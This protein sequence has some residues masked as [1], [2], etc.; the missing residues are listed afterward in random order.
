MQQSIWIILIIQ[1]CCK[2]G[3]IC[4][5]YPLDPQSC[6]EKT[7]DIK[8]QYNYV[9]NKCIE[10]YNTDYGCMN[11]LNRNSC[12][13][14]LVDSFNNELRCLFHEKCIQAT[15][16]HLKTLECNTNFSKFSCLNVNQMDCVW[17]AQCLDYKSQKPQ[18]HYQS[19]EEYYSQS[20][21]P[22]M[23]AKIQK[24][25]CFHGGITM[26]YKCITIIDS[27]LSEMKCSQKGINKNGCILI[28]TKNETCIFKNNQC[29]YI[30]IGSLDSCEFLNKQACLLPKMNNLQCQW[31]QQRCTI[32]KNNNYSCN[33]L[34]DVNPSVCQ[35]FEGICSYNIQTQGCEEVS[36]SQL[37]KLPCS[38][39]GLSQA[40]C[41]LIKNNY[42]TF[43]KGFCETLSEEDLYIYK[44]DMFLNEDSCTNIKTQFQY[45]KWDGMKCERTFMN[46][47]QDCKEKIDNSIKYNGLF[48]QHISKEVACKYDLSSKQCVPSLIEDECNSPYLNFFGCLSITAHKQT[49]QWTTKGC[50]LITVF[51]F[52]TTCESLGYANYNSCAQV[53]ENLSS[54]CYYEKSLYKCKKVDLSINQKLFLVSIDCENK[55]L[56]LNRIL[57]ASVIKPQTACRWHQNEC[58]KINNPKEI[59]DVSCQEMLFSNSI[60]C[61]MTQFN[62]E[63]CRFEESAKGCINSVKSKFSC[64]SPGLNSFACSQ[65]DN[66]CYFNTNKFQCQVFKT[67][68]SSQTTPQDQD[69]N[70]NSNNNQKIYEGQNSLN[71]I[72]SSPTKIICL[73]ITKPGQLCQWKDKL[74]KCGEVIVTLNQKCTSFKNVNSNVCASVFMENPDFIPYNEKQSVGY[75]K[76][77]TGTSSCQVL[78][79]SEICDT[80]CCTEN[81]FI[82]INRHTCS[83]LTNKADVYCYFDNYRCKELTQNL[84]DVTNKEAVKQYFNANEFNCSQM[85]KKSCHL[86]EWSTQQW[87]YFNGI[88]CQNVNFENQSNFKIFTE[89]P[90]IL[91]KYACLAIEASTT[92]YNIDKYFEYDPINHRCISQQYQISPPFY[93][94][95]E[96]V[97]GNSNICLRFTSNNYCKWDK[98]QLKCVTIPLDEFLDMTTCYQNQNIKA[99]SE[100]P[101]EACFFSFDLDKCISAVTYVPCSYFDSQGLVSQK[102]CA[103]IDLPQ[104][105]CEWSNYSCQISVKTSSNCDVKGANK[106]TCYKNT[107]GKCRWSNE[108]STCYEIAT[109]L[110]IDELGCDD[111]LN[112]VLCKLVKKESC[113]WDETMYECVRF[114]YTHHND[115]IFLDQ[116]NFYNGLACLNITGA[117]YKYDEKNNKCILIQDSINRNSCKQMIND[118]ACLYLTRGQ[119]CV[120]DTNQMP[121]CQVFTDDQSLCTT[122]KSIS[123]EVCMKIPKQC[124]FSKSKLQCLI[125]EIPKS[126]TCSS[127]NVQLK[128]GNHYNKLSCS[129]IDQSLTQTYQDDQCYQSEEKKQKCNYE[130]YCEWHD[131]IYGC[132]VKKLNNLIFDKEHTEKSSVFEYRY[133]IDN[134]TNQCNSYVKTQEIFSNT[135]NV[136]L[137]GSSSPLIC[138]QNKTCDYQDKICLSNLD[139]PIIYTIPISINDDGSI[140][141]GTKQSQLCTKKC[142][143]KG[144]IVCDK[145]NQQKPEEILKNAEMNIQKCQGKCNNT[146]KTSCFEDFECGYKTLQ[147]QDSNNVT[148]EILIQNICEKYQC[149]QGR[150]NCNNNNKNDCPDYVQKRWE[151]KTAQCV[152][153]PNYIITPKCK[154]FGY[155]ELKCKNTFSKVLCLYG[156]LE[157]CMFDLNQGGC[158]QLEGNENKI[159]DCSAISSRC[160]PSNLALACDP[161]KPVCKNSTHCLKEFLNSC[162]ASSN[163]R[164]LCKAGQTKIIPNQETCFSLQREIQQ[165]EP[166]KSIP[167][168]LSCQMM[169]G[170]VS[171][172]LCALANDNCRYENNYC[173]ST[174]PKMIENEYICDKS[175]SKSLCEK[176]NCFFEFIGYC[177]QKPLPPQLNT[178]MSNKYYLCHEVNQLNIENKLNVCVQVEQACKFIN[179]KCEDATHYNC[180]QLKGYYT[181][182][183]ACI[184][185]Q[186]AS[187]QYDISNNICTYLGL[188]N[189]SNCY[190]LNQ[191]ACLQ[192]TQKIMC[193]WEDYECKEIKTITGS[194]KR[195]CSIYNRDACIQFQY[196]CWFD[197]NIK[198]CIKFDPKLGSCDLLLNKDLCMYSLKESCLWDQNN[199]ICIKNDQE[200]T[201]CQGLNKFGCLNQSILQCVWSDIYGCQL[202]DFNNNSQS[203][204]S[205][206]G[207]SQKSYIT[208]FSKKVCSSININLNCFQDNYYRCRKIII[209]DMIKCD[210]NGLNK[211]GC[212]NRSYGKCQYLDEQKECI[213]IQNDQIGCIDSLNKEACISQKQTCKFENNTC[214]FHQVNKITDII[215]QIENFPYSNSVCSYLDKQIQQSFLYSQVQNRCIDVSNR[216][217]FIDN[218]SMVGIN[219][220]ACQQKTILACEY[221]SDENIC[222]KTEQSILKTINTCF[223][224]KY[225]NWV[226]CISLSSQCKFIQNKCLPIESKDNCQYLQDQ[227]IIVKSSICA[228]RNDKGCKLNITSN[229]CEI[230]NKGDN[231]QCT[232][233][234]LN[235]IGCLFQTKGYLCK[236]QQDQCFFDFQETVCEDLINEDK[237]YSIKTKGQYCRFDQNK[238]C[239]QI[240]NS[241]NELLKCQHSFKTNPI[242]CSISIDVPCFYN[243]SSKTCIKYQNPQGE[244]QLTNQDYFIFNLQSFNSQ[245]CQ[246]NSIARFD[247][248]T[249]SGKLKTQ[250]I[251]EC[252]E[253][254]EVNLNTLKCNDK[255]NEQSCISIQTPFQ[256]CQFTNQ[257]CKLSNLENFKKLQCQNISKIN[258]GMFCQVNQDYACQFNKNTNSCETVISSN[259]IYCVD[260]NPEV[261]GFSKKA[262]NLNRECTFSNG[263]YQL[264]ATENIKYCNEF[265][266]DQCY[267]PK[268]EGCKIYQKKCMAINLTEYSTINCN[269]A[270]NKLG[271]LNI[272]TEKQFCQYIEEKCELISLKEK[273]NYCLEF[274]SI[275]SPVFC[276][277]TIDIPCKYNSQ[278]YKC[279]NAEAEIEF[280]CIR[281]LNQRACLNLTKQSL[282]CQFYNY[283]EIQLTNQDYF[284]FNLQSFN[285]QACQINSIARFDSITISGKL[286]TQWIGE[287]VEIFEV[288]LNTLKCNDK[289]NEQSCISIQT[290]FQYCQFTNQQC[291]L[292]NLENFK[293]LQCQN[294]SKINSGMFC[295]VNQDY[296]CQF[297]KNTNSCETVISSNQIYCVDDNP[298]VLGFSKKACNLN[299]ECT[300]SNGCYQLKATENIKYCNEFSI[301]QCYKPKR[302]GCKIYQKKCMAINLTEYSTINCNEAANKLGC[303]NIKTEKQFCQYIEEKCE[304]I[305]LKEKE[306]YC[307]EFSSIN[308]PRIKLKGLFESYKIIFIICLFQDQFKCQ[309]QNQQCSK[310]SEQNLK[311]Q[312]CEMLTNVSRQ[313]CYEKEDSVCVFNID[314]LGCIEITPETCDQVQ[315]KEQCNKLQD[316]PCYW[317]FVELQCLFKDKNL[318]DGCQEIQNQW[319]SQRACLDVEK[320]GQMCK[321]DQ[322]CGAYVQTQ[323]IG[324]SKQL[325]KQSCLKQVFHQ[326]FWNIYKVDIKKT[327]QSKSKDK[328]EFGICHEYNQESD[329]QCNSN[330]S[331]LTC[332]NINTPNIFCKWEDNECKEVKNNQIFTL[333]SFSQ[334]NCNTCGIINDGSHA[335]CDTKNFKCQNARLQKN[336]LCDLPG[337]N[338]EACFY[339]QGQPCKWDDTIKRCLKQNEPLNQKKFN[340]QDSCKL[341]DVN[342]QV[343]SQL[344]IPLPCGFFE[345]SCDQVDLNQISCDYPGLNQYACLKIKNHPCGWIYDDIQKNYEC[346]FIQDFDAC[347][348]YNYFVNPFVCTQVTHEPCFYNQN[349]KNCVLFQQ[350]Q[351]QCNLI[352]INSIGCSLIDN[353]VFVKGNCVKYDKNMNLSCEDA[354]FSN[355]KV[356]SQIEKNRCKY[357]ILGYGCIS[358]ELQDICS[359]KGINQIGCNELNECQW[360]QSQCQCK[361]MI[362]KYPECD[363]ITVSKKCQSL[364]YCIIDASNSQYAID[365]TQQL[366]NSNLAK[367]KRKTCDYYNIDQCDGQQI[368]TQICYLNTNKEC[369][370]ASK[371]EEIISPLKDCQKYIIKNK[372]CLIS[373]VNNN[374]VASPECES[375]D[376]NMCLQFT[377]DCIFESVCKTLDC[378]YFRT[379]RKCVEKKCEWQKQNKSCIN[380]KKCASLDKEVCMNSKQNGKQCV[381]IGED[382]ENQ[383]C[384]DIGCRY[385]QIKYSLCN[386]AQIGEDAC[387]ALPDSTCVSCQEIIDPCIC[388]LFQDS[389]EY[390]RFHNICKSIECESLN[391]ET[392]PSTRC[393][394]DLDKQICIPF[395]Q[396]NYSRKQCNIY[397]FSCYW[398]NDKQICLQIKVSKSLN[399]PLIIKIKNNQELVLKI[400]SLIYILCF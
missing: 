399:R 36:L 256:Y 144:D 190:F 134:C 232:T 94:S 49:C 148:S 230:L 90:S 218:C 338:R 379:E 47:D 357:N 16:Y 110:E 263:C 19:C 164:V 37:N 163:Q 181:T 254:F 159:P 195:E 138:G 184:R 196:D 5:L 217:P 178:N 201:G 239:Y 109:I 67:S 320:Q 197:L 289:L 251:G 149:T 266:I 113:M 2:A 250:W 146:Q 3:N 174:M 238:G 35:N 227:Q 376:Y 398:D 73:L 321:Y 168:D 207:N 210:S 373:Q 366:I 243:I 350:K 260:D 265:S 186:G 235:K 319:G 46:Q 220:Y 64:D 346:K 180:E 99:C 334:V 183:K 393:Q 296:A 68:D 305:S 340:S 173:V 121:P 78:D 204:D 30:D 333:K 370:Q 219:R 313:V 20:V 365:I 117:G 34:A 57:C 257:Q 125:A 177:Q 322:K 246:I 386:G 170:D 252:V 278:Q 270:A 10:F 43:Y 147:V 24:F 290:P 115:F 75:C 143:K 131:Q 369:K 281:G 344:Y 306:N 284:I 6:I 380:S 351:N 135:Y 76:Y 26:D 156:V 61:A 88:A 261:L 108:T 28:T 56:G 324:C 364:N 382:E 119:N 300:F 233:S 12:I 175:F 129:S 81:R 375:L 194:D 394:F 92:V 202:A 206:I 258:S 11:N 80:N 165:C 188:G 128:F 172:S 9:E 339:V 145:Q 330:L 124:Y 271:C 267:K 154:G 323:E 374:C 311:K 396:N 70:N 299:R 98:Q 169:I 29:Q 48:C 130:N 74:D 112:Q 41:L 69:Q 288:N 326:C 385:L 358:S 378:K 14:Q 58:V 240:D 335:I 63:P 329:F 249:I 205:P 13:S 297:N 44:C 52:K 384:T 302:E 304:L 279:E 231:F 72:E 1:I 208:H 199:E 140:N 7:S 272:K 314:Q 142:Q 348:G 247:S 286:K 215:N 353:C 276:E 234:G 182:V 345:S 193:K 21:S 139:C 89:E 332:L 294:I 342:V 236:F 221:D 390:D 137:P 53:I 223:S 93:A 85:G 274:S 222:L 84:V 66:A 317:N 161:E 118:Y 104:Q 229:T 372:Q 71:C 216:N 116:K 45:C 209:T 18:Q 245:A 269:E 315:T 307:L 114:P 343:C 189:I 354:L 381:L 371:C 259:Q 264:K 50:T 244:I 157:E 95:C 51:P 122:S 60:S 368:D 151:T 349:Q 228:T 383:F 200:I 40:A 38:T 187:T 42:C 318:N 211:F 106:Y 96:D 176:C 355:Y 293:K 86:I 111:N 316:L 152:E 280:Q 105:Q 242:T 325:N 153:K 4:S 387:V 32:F 27:Q 17:Q 303:L 158:M 336:I 268:R 275:N 360:N 292:S 331:Y 397:D 212:I 337:M 123:I 103:Q 214:S 133:E 283:C 391:Q 310:Y 160:Q 33:Q 25:Q 101:H 126:Q 127:L 59:S 255:L 309:W 8:C 65:L 22:R 54:G 185:C 192:K 312:S 301:D 347:L 295:Q 166:R 155:I 82:G 79:G 361:S 132:Q 282:Q 179:K 136:L 291:K 277:N 97:Q 150:N 77:N 392:C 107:Q 400:L 298:E 141:N 388:L 198:Q 367:C 285:S 328:I 341:F 171:P 62:Q 15:S 359:A 377:D 273:E 262:C 253:I 102:V 226:S 100:N 213:E 31:T 248:I 363:L 120:Y 87:C 191:Q 287:C 55:S 224:D 203:C 167:E 389:C 162:L 83:R 352:G 327:S 225:L 362:N 241:K 23:C 356:C 91:N 395:C 237:C 39:L 308:S